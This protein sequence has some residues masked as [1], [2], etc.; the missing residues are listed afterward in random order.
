MSAGI[1]GAF[2]DA[3]CKTVIPR[4]VIGKFSIR[5]VPNMDPGSVER[6]VVEY[7]NDVHRTRDSPNTIKF[8]LSVMSFN[9]QVYF[10]Y[11]SSS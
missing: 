10:N 9:S 4:K 7:L 3:G 5:I 11:V 8:V 1:Q 2:D 6:L